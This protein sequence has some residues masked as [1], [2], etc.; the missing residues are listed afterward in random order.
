MKKIILILM[1]CSTIAYGDNDV[2][3]SGATDISQSNQSGTNTS[4]SGGY[5]SETTY[6]TGS[7]NSTTTN[8]TTNANQ[9]DTR[10]ANT[11]SAP[12]LSNFSQ[13][14]CSI[15]YTGGLQVLGGGISGGS[16]KRDMNCEMMKLA[17]LLKD[18]NLPVASIS[19]LCQDAR[20]FYSLEMAGTTC[21]FYSKIGAE[22]AAAWKKYPELRPDYEEYK[23]RMAYMKEIDNATSAKIIGDTAS[24]PKR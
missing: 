3:S 1:L 11:A 9:N 13:D 23:K 22:A 14:V 8:N 16:S 6:A 12:A 4:I 20:I 7:S 2:T 19:L 21:P 18:I 24:H 5:N 17:K 10:V 15:A